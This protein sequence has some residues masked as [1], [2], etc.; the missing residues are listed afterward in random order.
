METLQAM[1]GAFFNAHVR[2]HFR[3]ICNPARAT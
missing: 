1:K 2:G 3:F